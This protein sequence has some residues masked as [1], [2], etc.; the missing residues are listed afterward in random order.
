MTDR[1]RLENAAKAAGN[2]VGTSR[3]GGGLL[4]ANDLYWNP[5]NDKG[6]ALEL[7]VK[8]NDFEPY[9]SRGGFRLSPGLTVEEQ[10]RAIFLAAAEIGKNL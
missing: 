1:E 4:M 3:A 2:P 6:Q 5:L 8:L 9:K 10:C 7:A